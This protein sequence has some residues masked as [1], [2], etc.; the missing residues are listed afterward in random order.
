MSTMAAET[1]VTAG[2][3]AAVS[4]VA[5]VALSSLGEDELLSVVREVEQ[6]RRRLEALDARLIA[7]L[8][9]RNLP[10]SI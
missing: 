1:V 2:L 6:A 8:E 9:Q 5:G 3:S 7:E 4:E 10:G